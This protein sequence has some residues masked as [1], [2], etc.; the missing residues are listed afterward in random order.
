[1]EGREQRIWRLPP[2]DDRAK[3]RSETFQGIADAMA[4]QWSEYI[5]TNREEVNDND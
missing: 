1:V 4:E 2:S 3:I 5:L